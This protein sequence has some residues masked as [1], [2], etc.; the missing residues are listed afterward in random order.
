MS[1]TVIHLTT[2]QN[3]CWTYPELKG[4]NVFSPTNCINRRKTNAQ[5][6]NIHKLLACQWWFLN[7]CDI[8]QQS[9]CQSKGSVTPAFSHIIHLHF[10]S[11]FYPKAFF[12]MLFSFFLF[13]A[14]VQTRW[15]QIPLITP[16]PLYRDRTLPTGSVDIIIII[17]IILK[18]DALRCEKLH[19]HFHIWRFRWQYK[20]HW[21][22]CLNQQHRVKQQYN[23]AEK[24]CQVHFQMKTKLFI[25]I[26]KKKTKKKQMNQ[27]LATLTARHFGM[28]WWCLHGHRE[29]TWK[30]TNSS[31]KWK[32]KI[33]K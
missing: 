32:I 14:F 28:R 15:A 5:I 31:P 20:I 24:A 23:R 12:K 16:K 13:I 10:R 29:F 22:D 9:D 19:C 1:L 25:Y 11:C 3:Q 4:W 27:K 17:I 33:H 21:G 6:C 26:K 30:E 8:Q 18:Q 7:W 2:G